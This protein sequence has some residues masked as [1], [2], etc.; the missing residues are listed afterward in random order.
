MLGRVRM[1]WMF[2]WVWVGVGLGRRDRR[3]V[4]VQPAAMLMRSLG[5]GKG[6]EVVEVEILVR[7]EVWMSG[8]VRREGMSVGSQARRIMSAVRMADGLEVEGRMVR[9]GEVEVVVVAWKWVL[10][11]WREVGLRVVAMKVR[12]R[13]GLLLVVVVVVVGW[14]SS[15][16]LRMAVPIF[17]KEMLDFW[18]MEEGGREEGREGCTAADDGEGWG[19]GLVWSGHG[20]LQ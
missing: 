20:C 11:R 10:R 17:P 3:A 2:F 18:V 19:W 4:V 7:R 15:R 16:P 5:L 12:G 1:I 13:E 14:V 6:L 8:S 9:V